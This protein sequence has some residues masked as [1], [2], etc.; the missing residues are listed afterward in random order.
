MT[1][2][3]TIAVADVAP[4]QSRRRLT[5]HDSG[6][7]RQHATLSKSATVI[8]LLSRAKGASLAEV[9][10]VTSWQPH[11]VRAF[12]SGLRKKGHLLTREQRK[13]G[14]HAY[15]IAELVAASTSAAAPAAMPPATPDAVAK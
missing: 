11:S 6:S 10:A 8:K 1:N 5:Q 9:T 14:E 4:V 7:A 15:H 13:T 3:D 12:L 2:I